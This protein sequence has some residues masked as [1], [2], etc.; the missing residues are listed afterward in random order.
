MHI[1]MAR[2]CYGFELLLPTKASEEN[3]G[4]DR[5]AGTASN[6]NQMHIRCMPLVCLFPAACSHDTVYQIPESSFPNS[7]NDSLGT[8]AGGSMAVAE[9]GDAASAAV[10]IM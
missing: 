7:G 9:A 5:A 2:R 10:G 8:M 4:C 3:R 1:Y 6:T